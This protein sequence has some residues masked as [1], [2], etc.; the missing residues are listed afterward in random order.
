MIKHLDCTLRDGGYYNH[1]DFSHELILDYLMAMAA[2][3]LDF[4][5]IGFRSLKNQG[6][7]GGC[8]FTTDAYLESL[9]IPNELQNKIGVMINGSELIPQEHE[10]ATPE[11][12]AKHQAQVLTKLFSCKKSSPVTLVR[13]A[14]HIHE[15]EMCLPASKWLKQQGYI[16]GFNL[17]QVAD[18]PLEEITK[19]AITAKNYPVD[20]VYFADS[21]GSLSPKETAEIVE[22]FKLGWKGELG[23]HTHDNMGQAVSN[24]QQAIESGVTW[25][26][27]T[28]TGMGR[29]PGNAQTEYL[30]MAIDNLRQLQGNPTKLFE[31]IRKYF[32]P[33][34]DQYGWGTNPYYYLAGKYGIHPSYIQQMMQDARYSDEDILAVIEH[35]KI[36]GGKKFC[37]NTLE[38]ARHFYSG[39][40]RGNW[41]PAEVM[42]GKDVLVIGTGPGVKAYQT[43]IENYIQT[44]QPYV[45]ALNTQQ[46]IAQEL[47]DA[48][49]AC[50]PVR[51]LAD[52]KEHL[53]LPQPLITPA[54]ML[55]E[56]V[57]KALRNKNLYDFG[58]RI[59]QDLFEFY[60]NYATLP[61]SLV[62]AYVLAIATSGQA[63]RILLVGFDGYSDGDPRNK[64]SEQV[65]QSYFK[66]KNALE[67]TTMTPTR[68][69]I[70]QNSIY[71][72]K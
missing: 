31:L 24:T 35:L 72:E 28:V 8:A 54:S 36:E 16:V 68:Y 59:D 43:A 25:V 21:M 9:N 12:L 40:P 65:F 55:P 15:F 56:D 14:C 64:E 3:Q 6:F 34:Q 46:N 2:L 44:K 38:S 18:R 48:R 69:R 17:M 37:L 45:I 47:I 71:G 29:G 33:M 51:L 32:K 70:N 49:A 66:A 62:M 39:K 63:N 22:S 67:V 53:K 42:Q 60:T 52:C 1:W 5:E 57:Q 61:T 26:D 27:S 23:I 50:H 4:V 30:S 13:I 20:V 7:K 19:I 41:N 11:N 10:S 58:I